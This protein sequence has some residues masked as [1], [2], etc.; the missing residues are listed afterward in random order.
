MSCSRC[1][2]SSHCPSGR[3]HFVYKLG[4]ID[5]ESLSDLPYGGKVRLVF[6]A[7]DAPPMSGGNTGGLRQLSLRHKPLDAELPNTLADPHSRHC[8]YPHT[9]FATFLS[10]LTNLAQVYLNKI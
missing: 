8:S 9:P 1:Q 4:R 5:A 7:L 10:Y 2:A 6:V 3:L